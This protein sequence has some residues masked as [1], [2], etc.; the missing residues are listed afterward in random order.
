[1]EDIL[2]NSNLWVLVSFL[3]FLYVAFKFGR[4][5][6]VSSLDSKIEKI[7]H[8]LDTAESLRV[9]AQ[10]LLAQYQRKQ[11][12]ASKEASKI[13]KTAEE[14]AAHI[15]EKAEADIEKSM[16][17][18]DIW[19]KERVA[20]MEEDALQDIR[21]RAI[22][23]AIEASEKVMLAHIDEKTHADM[24]KKTAKHIPDNVH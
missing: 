18:R 16:K 11:R 3:I 23:L 14:H 7:K 8:D 2:H 6:V 22:D 5:S 1:M 12:E 19:L 20:R 17:R 15:Q 21:A 4:Q 13:I 24:V 9:E 10:E